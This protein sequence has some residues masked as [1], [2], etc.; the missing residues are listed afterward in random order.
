MAADKLDAEHHKLKTLLMEQM[1][2]GDYK[3]P[4]TI[5]I[6]KV[7]K[8][9]KPYRYFQLSQKKFIKS[10][11]TPTLCLQNLNNL[12]YPLPFLYININSFLKRV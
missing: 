8:C 10:I 6:N 7:W 1:Q 5:A 3:Q 4:N 9:D 11:D 2:L 12:I